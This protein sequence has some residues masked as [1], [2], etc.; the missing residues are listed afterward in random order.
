MDLKLGV[1][2]KTLRLNSKKIKKTDKI[3]RGKKMY[4]I[5]AKQRGNR[6]PPY[7]KKD[8]F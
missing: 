7:N 8:S 4:K 6:T 3:T 5:I 2:L 1:I